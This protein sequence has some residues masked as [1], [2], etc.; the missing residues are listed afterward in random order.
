[1]DSIILATGYLYSF[2]FL[3]EGSGIH[4][5][6]GKCVFSLYSNTSM[7]WHGTHEV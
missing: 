6:E 5:H 1:M 4:V 3:S 7:C 2:P